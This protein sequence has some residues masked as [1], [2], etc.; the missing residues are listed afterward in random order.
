[1]NKV[2]P[3]LISSIL[4]TKCAFFDSTFKYSGEIVCGLDKEK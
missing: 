1:M 2:A 3:I 4:I